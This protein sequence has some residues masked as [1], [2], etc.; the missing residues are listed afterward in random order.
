M[1]RRAHPRGEHGGDY[2]IAGLQRHPVVEAVD[3]AGQ[4][5]AAAS[6]AAATTQPIARFASLT[7]FFPQAGASL[8]GHQTQLQTIKKAARAGAK[9]KER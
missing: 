6:G 7:G 1:S 5:P 2:R 3:P 9:E 4:T 8:H